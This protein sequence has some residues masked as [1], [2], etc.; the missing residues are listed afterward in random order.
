MAWLS[1]DGGQSALLTALS[2]VPGFSDQQ[3]VKRFID[4]LE[5]RLSAG[6]SFEQPSAGLGY[7]YVGGDP[8][9]AGTRF[10]LGFDGTTVSFK[11]QVKNPTSGLWINKITYAEPFPANAV[12]GDPGELVAASLG[13]GSA[14]GI[15]S[16]TPVNVCNISLT[17]GDWDVEGTCGFQGSTPTGV[18][19]RIAT[20]ST[21]S[22]T[23]SD[24]AYSPL[25]GSVVTA[26]VTTIHLALPRKRLSLSAASTT[27]YLCGRSIFT[28][29]SQWIYGSLSARRAR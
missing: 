5:G 25:N 7:V 21:I 20:I 26:G 29:G 23:V 6:F 4:V 3:S 16:N 14:F 8:S 13:A 11:I 24:D 10:V 15:S 28:G 22:A 12:A 17:A 18:T 27:V 19:E 1:L 9:S 2:R